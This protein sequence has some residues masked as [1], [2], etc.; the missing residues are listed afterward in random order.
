MKLKQ[1][2]EI[3]TRQI[4]L[5]QPALLIALLFLGYF[6]VPLIAKNTPIPAKKSKS[7]GSTLGVEVIK[8]Q[9]NEGMNTVVKPA[10][11]QLQKEAGVV[12]GLAQQTVQQTVQNI[13]STSANQAKEF[14]FDNTLG[15]V[16]ENINT[17][18]KDQ[19]DLIKKAICK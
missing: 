12:L 11:D 9:L 7:I 10:A 8:K 6:V 2:E 18:P 15:K 16:L 4:P 14:V 13:A 5:W 1:I 17:L 19:Q 3:A